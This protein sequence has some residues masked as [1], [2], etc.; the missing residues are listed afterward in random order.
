VSDNLNYRQFGTC[1]VL[2]ELE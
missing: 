2:C 1:P